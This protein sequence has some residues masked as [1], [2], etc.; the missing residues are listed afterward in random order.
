LY[1]PARDVEMLTIKRVID[2][3][4]IGAMRT[5]RCRPVKLKKLTDALAAFVIVEQRPT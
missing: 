1:Q 3:L 5:C 2:A 4:E